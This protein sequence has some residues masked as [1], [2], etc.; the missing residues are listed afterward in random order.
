MTTRSSRMGGTDAGQPTG[1]PRG[2][3]LRSAQPGS[4]V[5]GVGPTILRG[6]V[7]MAFAASH[8]VGSPQLAGVTVLPRGMSKRQGSA[9]GGSLPARI[10][11]G[12]AGET[13]SD[14]PNFERLAYLAVT[15]D[16]L[17]LVKVKTGRVTTKLDEVIVRIPCTDVASAE[18]GSGVICPLTIRFGNGDI[19]KTRYGYVSAAASQAAAAPRERRP[20]CIR[21]SPTMTAALGSTL[22]TCLKRQPLEDQL[23]GQGMAS[24][25]RCDDTMIA[26]CGLLIG[27][28]SN[29]M[30]STLRRL[31]AEQHRGR[32]AAANAWAR[33]S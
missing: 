13:A 1:F 10:A 24:A 32:V 17:A 11:L 2:R 23:R 16:E 33:E 27:M 3:R 21:G 4:K 5:T 20:L 25:K 12:P 18:L 30:M 9:I 31:I 14:A 6:S 22:R 7:R 19:W 26:P 28:E 29:V 8:I 15:D